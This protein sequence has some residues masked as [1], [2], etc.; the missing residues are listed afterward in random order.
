MSIWLVI[1][2]IVIILIT[3]PILVWV[4]SYIFASA[5]LHAIEQ[6]LLTKKTNSN[7]RKKK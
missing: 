1:L 2:I 6:F 4:Y 3:I 5:I 7:E